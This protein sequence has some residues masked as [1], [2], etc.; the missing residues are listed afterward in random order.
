M[1]PAT[2]CLKSIDVVS[3]EEP[4]ETVS[5][6]SVVPVVDDSPDQMKTGED[7]VMVKV[8]VSSTVDTQKVSSATE[9]VPDL[10]TNVRGEGI[11]CDPARHPEHST[12]CSNFITVQKEDA[13]E[14]SSS[15]LKSK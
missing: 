1:Y 3:V 14:L 13:K 12:F 8:F 5:S 11:N 7:S 10:S 15:E 6:N 4:K 2:K 9:L